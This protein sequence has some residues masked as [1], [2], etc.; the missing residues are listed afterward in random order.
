M[1]AHPVQEDRRTL[2]TEGEIRQLLK[3]CSRRYPSGIRNRA[4][5][6]LLSGSGLRIGE[7]LALRPTDVHLLTEGQAMLV[8]QRGKGG[9]T[10]TAGLLPGSIHHIRA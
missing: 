1:L 10:R 7:A 4:L 2:L 5:L 8:V 6:A 9:K 3:A